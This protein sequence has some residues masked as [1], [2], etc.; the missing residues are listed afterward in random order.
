MYQD[1]KLPNVWVE[2][3]HEGSVTDPGVR[4]PVKTGHRHPGTLRQRRGR[5]CR[6]D[7]NLHNRGVSLESRRL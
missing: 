3:I 6:V 5:S 2:T 4:N 7:E 1:S